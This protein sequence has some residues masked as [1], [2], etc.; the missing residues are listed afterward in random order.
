MKRSFFCK[1]CYD[2]SINKCSSCEQLLDIVDSFDSYAPEFSYEGS[3]GFKPNYFSGL[4]YVVEGGF[5]FK[6]YVLILLVSDFILTFE[7]KR[8]MRAWFEMFFLKQRQASST[9][10]GYLTHI[11]LWNVLNEYT[12]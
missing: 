12:I 8:G 5:W 2:S 11:A 9:K 1:A 3:S 10:H 6:G 4:A 7:I